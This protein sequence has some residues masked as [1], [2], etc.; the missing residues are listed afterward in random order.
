MRDDRQ[1]YFAKNEARPLD[2]ME[3]LVHEMHG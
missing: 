2:Q 1:E 3:Y